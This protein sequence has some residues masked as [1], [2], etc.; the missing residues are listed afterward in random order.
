M[1]VRDLL[2][3]QACNSLLR[4]LK[5]EQCAMNARGANLN[6][7]E[8]HHEWAVEGQD[9]VDALAAQLIGDERGARLRNRALAFRFS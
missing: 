7:K 3:A 4:G 5:A 2:T 9:L 6:P 1:V 8:L